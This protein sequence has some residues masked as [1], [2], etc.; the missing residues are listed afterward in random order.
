MRAT[1]GAQLL[2]K[3]WPDTH[4]TQS[5]AESCAVEAR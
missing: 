1:L 5:A 3:I 4:P 2:A